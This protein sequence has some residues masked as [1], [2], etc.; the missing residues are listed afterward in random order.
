M[1]E[2]SEQP[3]PAKRPRLEA[4][5]DAS[6][7]LLLAS[8]EKLVDGVSEVVEENRATYK[9]A[10]DVQEFIRFQNPNG[11][12]RMFRAMS[13]YAE[14]MSSL[15]VATRRQLEDLWKAQFRDREVREKVDELLHKE[16]SFDDLL[17]EIE[18]ELKKD[19]ATLAAPHVIEEGEEVPSDL[20]LVNA[21]TGET[22]K[23]GNVCAKDI[24]HHALIVLMRHFG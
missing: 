2:T 15:G 19:E 24:G 17:A 4:E 22:E 7:S 18:E 23:L 6:K 20:S 10:Q 9:D 12:R 21:R 13:M 14:C 11:V 3:G 8:L 16:E 1:A 5:G